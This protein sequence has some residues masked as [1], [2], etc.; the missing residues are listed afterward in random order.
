M[1]RSGINEK[2]E[3]VRGG[4]RGEMALYSVIGPRDDTS[5]TGQQL[6]ARGIGGAKSG[7]KI[8]F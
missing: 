4:V 8:G 7:R 3:V 2:P 6:T 5:N 1:R